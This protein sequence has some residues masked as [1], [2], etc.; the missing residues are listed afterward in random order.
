[1]ALSLVMIA[2]SDSWGW[3]VCVGGVAVMGTACTLGES[4]MLGYTKVRNS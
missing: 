3:G 2:F 1:M 4:V